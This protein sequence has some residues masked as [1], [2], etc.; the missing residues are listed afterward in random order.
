MLC[1]ESVLWLR[2]TRK[3]ALFDHVEESLSIAEIPLRFRKLFSDSLELRINLVE[4]SRVKRCST[5]AGSRYNNSYY[6]NLSVLDNSLHR[7]QFQN[8]YQSY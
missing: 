1:G 6:W 3:A 7:K 8:Y 5:S 4:S 2:I